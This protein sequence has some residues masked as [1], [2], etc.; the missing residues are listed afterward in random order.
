M[1]WPHYPDGRFCDGKMQTDFH[2]KKDYNPSL[3][4]QPASFLPSF[5]PYGILG[6]ESLSLSSVQKTQELK[7]KYIIHSEEL[8]TITHVL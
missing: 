5:L 8:I 2:G 4:L 7:S 6:S 3:N 1:T